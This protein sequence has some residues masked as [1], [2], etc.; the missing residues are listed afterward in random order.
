MLIEHCGLTRFLHGACKPQYYLHCLGCSAGAAP[1]Y[2]F[3]SSKRYFGWTGEIAFSV[4]AA[5]S[6]FR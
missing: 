6:M 3:N 2:T 4:G 1:P 5:G